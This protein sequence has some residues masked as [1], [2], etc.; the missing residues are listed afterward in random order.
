MS[1]GHFDYDQYRI[2]GIWGKIEREIEANDGPDG[3]ELPDEVLEKF[4]EAVEVLKKAEIYTHRIDWLLSSDDGV[5]T[6][7]RRLKADLEASND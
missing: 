1:G 3:C 5:E 2:R 6:F 7:L 4:R